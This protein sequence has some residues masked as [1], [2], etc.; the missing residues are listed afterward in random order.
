[1]LMNIGG[2][3][4]TPLRDVRAVADRRAA[5]HDANA[6]ADA[7]RLSGIVSLS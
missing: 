7:G 1:M 4:M 5:G 3:Q 2:M 6:A